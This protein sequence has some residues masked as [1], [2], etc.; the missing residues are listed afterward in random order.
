MSTLRNRHEH[1][2]LPRS[3]DLAWLGLSLAVAGVV[4]LAYLATHTTPA[5]EGGLFLQIV[6][7]IRAGGD[8]LPEQIPYYVHADVPFAYPPLWFYATAVLADLTGLDPATVML[9]LP[10]LATM[11]SVAIFYLTARE[12]LDSRSQA[13][14]AAVLFATTPAVLRWHISAGGLVRAP[15]VCLALAGVYAGLRRFRRGDRRWLL[16]GALLF[17]LT[18]LSHPHYAAFFGVSYLV[19][20]AVYDRTGRGFL[21][22]AVVALGGLLVAAPWLVTALARHGPETVL[23]AAGSHQ[24]LGGGHGRLKAMFVSP[25]ASLDA[26]LAFFALAFAGT[27]Y[28]F[29]GRRYLLPV[30]L[31]AVAYVIGRARFLFVPGAMASAVLLLDASGAPR[32]DLGLDRVRAAVDRRVVVGAVV[33]GA[34][35]LGASFAGS[36]LATDHAHSTSQP[37]TVDAADRDAMAWVARQTEPTASFVVLGDAA[38]WFPYLADRRAALGPWGLEWTGAERYYAEVDRFVRLSTCEAANCLTSGLAAADRHPD[39][40]YV[41]RGEYTVRGKEYEQSA[42]IRTSLL[43]SDRYRLAYE[44]GGVMIFAVEAAPATTTRPH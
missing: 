26:E 31:F 12:V 37:Q 4:V 16:P 41:P 5:H 2:T 21:D 24:G 29:R 10:G 9:Y 38:E 13:G 34:T 42:G 7:E 19:L 20:Y 3:R 8:V 1:P 39:Y 33:L 27:L 44:N 15:A 30:W 14:L 32:F 17:G 40:L 18:V 23:G 28:L 43:A 22:G 35:V 11:A 6:A 25:L 36:A